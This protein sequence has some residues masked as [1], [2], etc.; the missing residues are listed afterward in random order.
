MQRIGILA[1]LCAAMAVAGFVAGY[2]TR[3]R[4]ADIAASRDAAATV[5]QSGANIVRSAERSQQVEA[6]IQAS[7]N[8][9]DQLKK[10][11]QARL[12]KEETHHEQNIDVE[13]AGMCSGRVLDFGTVRLLN[14]ARDQGAVESAA[15]GPHEIGTV[16]QVE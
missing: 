10:T 14:R 12:Q 15:G 8:R 5:R 11:A 6:S 2:D 3:S 1:A 4:L 7:D 9:I 16:A 13:A